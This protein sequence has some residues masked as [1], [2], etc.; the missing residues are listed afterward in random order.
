MKFINTIFH[1]KWLP[2]FLKSQIRSNTIPISFQI[3]R[4]RSQ[5]VKFVRRK[6]PMEW[7]RL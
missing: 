5:L 7:Y 3:K 4:K 1:E 2:F 6:T